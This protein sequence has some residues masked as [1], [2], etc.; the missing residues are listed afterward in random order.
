MAA[1]Y[2]VQAQML[3]GGSHPHGDLTTARNLAM[4]LCQV[5]CGLTLNDIA[6]AFHLGHYTS[7]S[8]AIGRIKRR[9]PSDAGLCE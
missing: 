8:T 2:G 6:E 3:I 9:L 7:V 1:S 5:R 4:W